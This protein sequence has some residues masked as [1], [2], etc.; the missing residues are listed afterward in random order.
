M[1]PCRIY[2]CSTVPYWSHPPLLFFHSGF[3]V[4]P[5]PL[6]NLSPELIGAA[7]GARFQKPPHIHSLTAAI[8]MAPPLTS[9][10]VQRSRRRSHRSMFDLTP[11]TPYPGSP[12]QTAAFPSIPNFDK[13][14]GRDPRM[15]R[16]SVLRRD[17]SFPPQVTKFVFGSRRQGF[18]LFLFS[19]L[20]TSVECPRFG[21]IPAHACCFDFCLKCPC[22]WLFCFVQEVSGG[23]RRVQVAI[24]SL[25]F[26]RFFELGCW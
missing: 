22:P 4:R 9:P 13:D 18:G 7:E 3:P 23:S 20:Y 12:G 11:F 24:N 15:S 2:G 10:F 19:R 14:S 8:P 16:V 17:P 26:E 6:R 5:R 1:E 25:V 21:F